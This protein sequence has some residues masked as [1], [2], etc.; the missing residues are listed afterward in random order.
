M[1][2]WAIKPSID[3]IAEVRVQTNMYSAETGRTLG[4]VIN[5]ITKSGG[6]EF[7][8]SGF[9]FARHEK[10]DSRSVLRDRASP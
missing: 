7:H 6:N 10:F 3:A 9:E 4:G 5:I 1:G 2:R 8:G